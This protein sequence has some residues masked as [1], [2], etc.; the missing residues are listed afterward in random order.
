[1]DTLHEPPQLLKIMFGQGASVVC[2]TS[3]RL[4]MWA[5][6]FDAWLA[7]LPVT[8][9]RRKYSQALK[10]WQLL[11]QFHHCPPWDIDRSRIESWLTHLV[12]SGLTAYTIHIYRWRISAFYRFCSKQSEFLSAEPL[13]ASST[14]PFNPVLTALKPDPS[15]YQQAYLLHP[16]EARA[17]L[18]AV[19]RQTSLLGKRDYALLL[20]LLLTGLSE[21][22]L[23]LLRWKHFEITSQSVKLISAS[24]D[25]EKEL[26]PA[27]W[28]AIL[29]FLQSSGRFDTIQP[30]D[31]IF[32]PL[33]NPLLGPPNGHPDDWQRDRP[34]S[35]ENM[36]YLLKGYAAWAGL[37]ASK[38]TYVCLRHTAAVLQL[39]AGAD[40]AMLQKFLRRKSFRAT[41]SYIVHLGFMLGKR[42]PHFSRYTRGPHHANW[43][44]YPR[45]TKSS[46]Q[47]GNQKALIHGLYARHGIFRRQG[48]LDP[49]LLEMDPQDIQA[50]A[51]APLQN[52]IA[53]LRFLLRRAFDLAGK[54]DN[55]SAAI[56]VLKLFSLT[57]I[58]IARLLLDQQILEKNSFQESIDQALFEV[59]RQ[60]GIIND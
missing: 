35:T 19:D 59:T 38:V 12:K 60:L 53:A 25:I 58:R 5:T 32:T 16:P 45:K 40:T 34:L 54:T 39:E 21:G 43:G 55:K 3:P 27:V 8:R 17:L 28:N 51:T 23:R 44:P 20:T 47:L 6:A 49:S 9:P 7:S 10:S 33:A 11:L 36:H 50:A 37:D 31:Y 15:N 18:R 42:K 14:R 22:A 1:M 29:T 30:E 24:P 13:F 41:R 48:F 57:S 2:S 56:L 46:S 4:D 52:E 26:P